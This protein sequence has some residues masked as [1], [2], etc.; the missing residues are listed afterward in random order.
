MYLGRLLEAELVV[1]M[2]I[3]AFYRDSFNVLE[4]AVLGGRF[5]L[6]RYLL[7]DKTAIHHGGGF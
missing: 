2:V 4:V 1:I 3:M 5:D 6:M 7:I